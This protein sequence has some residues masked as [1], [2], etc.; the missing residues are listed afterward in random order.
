M[1][2]HFVIICALTMYAFVV[3][4]ALTGST[5]STQAAAPAGKSGSAV[6][7]AP[8]VV[9]EGLPYRAVTL[10][11]QRVDWIDRYKTCIDE[12][13]NLGANAVK[14]VVDA[15]QENAGSSKI[16]LDLRMTPNPEQL[17]ELI[18]YAKKKKLH[19]ILMPIV[20]I[21][22][23]R[24]D[25]EWRGRIAPEG[26]RGWEKWWESYQAM[27]GHFAW[28]AQS[29][30]VDVLVIGSELVS[31]NDM[32]DDWT[33]TINKVR[34][35]FKGSITYSSN[36]D[37]YTAVKIWDQ[38]DLISMNCYWTFGKKGTNEQPSIDQIKVEWAK[39]KAE[40]LDFQRQHGK[41]VFFSEVGWCSLA[42]MAFEPWDYTKTEYALDLD[43]QRR[44]YEGFF[45]SWHGQKEL[46]GFSIWEWDPDG[47][48]PKD[49][50]YTPKGKPA[51][52]VL[53]AWLAKQ[54]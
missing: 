36:W 49:R 50:G 20:L 25:R 48:G 51:E 30:G 17:G 41:P 28:I 7:T 38:L 2:R 15:R 23:P 37:N 43:L 46:G 31:T 16:Y 53:R 34:A 45:Q 32:I 12:I 8:V 47:G 10:Q 44:L 29:N 54:W 26:N 19:V 21:D 35:T 1:V 5:N 9:A 4:C 3:G 39:V 52:Q 11:I 13:A 27:M 18:Q 42:N 6:P 22:A 14:F 33:D 40:V 24:N